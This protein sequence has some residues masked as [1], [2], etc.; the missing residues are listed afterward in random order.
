MII[1]FGIVSVAT[2]L[3]APG[4]L[5]WDNLG[6]LWGPAEMLALLLLVSGLGMGMAFPAANNACIELMPGKVA[7]I[8]ALRNMF[9]TIGGALGV[10]VITFI[11]HLAPNSTSGFRIVFVSLGLALLFSLPLGF[12]MPTGKEK[13]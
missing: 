6:A 1:G 13:E 8:V 11:L 5:L 10:S 2:I 9:R 7:T 12:L 3:L 4:F